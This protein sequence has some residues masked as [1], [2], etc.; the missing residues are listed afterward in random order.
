M[1]S[2]GLGL[3]G[4]IQ[5]ENRETMSSLGVASGNPNKNEEL[6]P[7][8]VDFGGKGAPLIIDKHHGN[9]GKPEDHPI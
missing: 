3:G 2:H 5:A 8:R 4:K 7:A 1:W 9:F 6:F